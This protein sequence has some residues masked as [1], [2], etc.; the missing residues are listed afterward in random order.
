MLYKYFSHN[1][2]VLPVDQAVV[3]LGNVEYAYG[4]GVY[5]T[6]RLAKGR[7]YF[8][9][10][11]ANRLLASAQVIDL[12]HD[13]TA[14]FVRQSVQDLIRQN[15]AE[16]CN[17]KLLLIG[18][19][20][21]QDASLYIMCLNPLFPDR[22]LYREGA[23]ALTYNYERDFPPAKT[24]SMLPSY[25]AYRQAKAAG[26]YD[27]LF[28]NRQGNIT[29]GTRTN[30]FTMQDKTIFSPPAQAVLPGITRAKMLEVALANGF[31]IVEQD[32][33]L[34]QIDQFTAAFLTSVSSKIMPLRAI[35]DH[36]FGPPS[37][38]LQGLMAAFDQFLTEY[39]QRG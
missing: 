14:D 29:E 21:V 1:G 38:E 37:P 26:G 19:R 27:A 35:D 20:T 31:E 2:A 8:L 30:F 24:L 28:I 23:T 16:T 22:K 25:L 17:L 34:S 15:G 7:I 11:H 13:F 39:S 10:E 5:E 33:K 4:F 6:I 36:E 3:S 32:I 9:D 18:G 12:Q